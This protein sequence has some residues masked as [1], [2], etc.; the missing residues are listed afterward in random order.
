M[1]APPRHTRRLPTAKCFLI[2][3]AAEAIKDAHGIWIPLGPSSAEALHLRILL[4]LQLIFFSPTPTGNFSS[5]HMQNSKNIWRD[6][7]FSNLCNLEATKQTQ[8]LQKPIFT[9]KCVVTLNVTLF[10][11]FPKSDF[12]QNSLCRKPPFQMTTFL[13]QHILL[14][15]IE[16]LILLL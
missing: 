6:S 1:P 10:F 9:G 7:I 3:I 16:P 11:S 2:I 15:S 13:T 12:I 14:P 8:K 5:A 4:K